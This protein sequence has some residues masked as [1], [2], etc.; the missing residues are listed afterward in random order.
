MTDHL[1]RKL[2]T[3]LLVFYGVGIMVGAGIYVLVGAAAGA[4]GIYAPLAF[5]A[6]ALVALPTAATYAE[7]SSRIPKSAGE[8]AYLMRAFNN[9][10]LSQAVGLL[11]VVTGTIAAAVVLQGGVGYLQKLLPWD[12]QTLT[13]V[14]GVLLTLIAIIG[15]VESLALAAIFTVVEVVGLLIVSYVGLTGPQSVEWATTPALAEQGGFSGLAFAGILAFFAFI[16]FEDLVNMAE[17]TR[18]PER[19]MPKAIFWSLGITTALYIMVTV[20][21]VRTVGI[22]ALG[23]SRQP[24][25]LVFETATQKSAAFLAVIAV[26]AATNG[27]LAQIIL[28]ARVLFGLGENTAW[29]SVFTHA[30]PRF[31]TPVLATVLGGITV[32]LAALY[33][34]LIALAEMTSVLLLAIFA[35]MNLTLIV[36]KRREPAAPYRVHVAV[37]WA[38]LLLSGAAL[39]MSLVWV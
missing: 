26:A 2:G 38:G 21:A 12:T 1:K 14:M 35:S 34:P 37:P 31:G 32:I 29:L 22:D 33:L 17:E 3:P 8:A 20:A 10:A 11:T 6:A 7:L 24:L 9:P 13:I 18:D 23:Q 25:A 5:L 16:G 19:T 27:V 30:H 15:V 36:I 28:A 4:A 39:V